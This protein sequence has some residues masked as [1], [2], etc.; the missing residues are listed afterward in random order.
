MSIFDAAAELGTFPSGV[1]LG[2][3]LGIGSLFIALE[4]KL[5]RPKPLIFIGDMLLVL[6]F[7]FCLFSL[8]VGMEGKLRY[9]TVCGT[10]LGFSA[11]WGCV[12]TIKNK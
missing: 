5:S 11:I 4:R 7:S 12:R 1:I 8:G 3:I 6:F 10:I 2:L 9:P